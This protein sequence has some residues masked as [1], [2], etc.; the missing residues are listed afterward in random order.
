MRV[1]QRWLWWRK[2][3]ALCRDPYQKTCTFVDDRPVRML[4]HLVP[5]IRLSS[6]TAAKVRP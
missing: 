1:F 4:F 6:G 2:R 5:E 3:A